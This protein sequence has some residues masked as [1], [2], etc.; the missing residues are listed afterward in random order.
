MGSSP[1]PYPELSRIH[2]F[3]HAG[4]EIYPDEADSRSRPRYTSRWSWRNG[5]EF[6]HDQRSRYREYPLH[7]RGVMDFGRRR[8]EGTGRPDPVLGRVTRA[9]ACVPAPPVFALNLGLQ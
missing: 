3:E 7:R 8:T 1:T 9:A 6:R 4:P 5:R 2:D